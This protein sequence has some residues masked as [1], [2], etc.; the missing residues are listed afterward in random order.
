MAKGTVIHAKNVK[1][2]YVDETYS[3]KMLIDHTNSLTKNVQ[4][5]MGIVAPGAKHSD[6]NHKPEYD[7]VYLIQSGR[8]MVRLDGVE[9]ELEAGDV[10]FIPGGAMHAIA[11]RSDTE[12]LIIFTVWSRLP[13]PGANPVYDQ[14]VNE[15]GKSFKT[16]DEE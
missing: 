6:H 9:H 12:E 8:A 5:N 2:L 10:V 15:W 16:V 3:S 1:T 7:E 11:N 14:R 4:I 13:E